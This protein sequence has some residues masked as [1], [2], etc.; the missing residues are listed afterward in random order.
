M[1]YT[2]DISCDTGKEDTRLA[3]EK[4]L[5]EFAT[6][7]LNINKKDISNDSQ[8]ILIDISWNGKGEQF[9]LIKDRLLALAS[10]YGVCFEVQ[11]HNSTDSSDIIFIGVG[12]L[13]KEV[14]KIMHDMHKLIPRLI[15]R[16]ASVAERMD[17]PEEELLSALKKLQHH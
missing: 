11:F 7:E 5:F 9:K 2:A 14:D 10:K 16:A 6:K 13:S 8:D 4:N 12:A 15:K 17:I 3:I 1:E